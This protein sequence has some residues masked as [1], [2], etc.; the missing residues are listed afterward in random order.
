MSQSIHNKVF[1]RIVKTKRGRVFL[2]SEFA[3]LGGDTA[4]RKA[5]S[6]L[7]QEGVLERLAQGIYLYPK[8]DPD[9]GVLYPSAETI[10]KH[11]A[12][13]DHVRIIPTGPAALNLVGL[14]TQVAMNLVYLTDGAPRKLKIG[15][16]TVVFKATTAKRVA[17]KGYLTMLVVQALRERGQDRVTERDLKRVKELL[18]REDERVI[19]HD[20]KLAPTWI[21]K[22]LK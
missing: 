14:S 8:T 21:A 3:D 18:Q 12:R 10:V 19:R 9:F 22:L 17:F 2:T 11:I 15:M 20:L 13:R 4:T 16:Q 1:N 5:L 7:V 6:R